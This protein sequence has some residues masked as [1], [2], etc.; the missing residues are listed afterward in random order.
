[1]SGR[2]LSYKL[3]V[4]GRARREGLGRLA[5]AAVTSRPLRNDLLPSIAL[6]YLPLDQLRPVLK[7]VRKLDPAHVREIALVIG[8][9]G[10]C[11]PILIG[12]DNVV[13]DGEARLEAA[14]LHGLDRVPCIQIGH[15][16]EKEQRML[17]L[18]LNRLAEKGEWDLDQLKIEFEELII[19]DA[20]I[21]VS[22]FSPDEVD[23]IIVVEEA[24]AIE[25]GPLCPDEN[26]VAVARPGDIF[27]L[28]PH[29]LICGDA[30]DPAV[31]RLLMHG[32]GPARLVLTDVSCRVT[33]SS[34]RF[35]DLPGVTQ[36][37]STAFSARRASRSSSTCREIS[38]A[39]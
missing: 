30:T 33:P 10:F 24:D 29:R 8:E 32:D 38:T 13:L 19:A 15:L 37:T 4:K 23:Q 2:S 1:M 22:G 14:R 27:G 18:A 28:G 26:A 31:L 3:R 12:R 21:E 36:I 39:G 25:N 34:S 11:H 20:P 9:L 16:S 5:A 6:A 35:A 17:R 7:K